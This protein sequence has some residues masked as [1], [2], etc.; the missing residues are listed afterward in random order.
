MEA[1]NDSS[2]RSEL[3]LDIG[4]SRC[5]LGVGARACAALYTTSTHSRLD[6]TRIMEKIKMNGAC[7]DRYQTGYCVYILRGERDGATMHTQY[8]RCVCA[9]TG[10][11]EIE[12]QHHP[13]F[14]QLK[15]I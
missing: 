4:Y 14:T 7:I 1:I 2:E 3:L 15:L 13:F 8:T 11:I 9:R 12:R 5:L 6:R 10:E